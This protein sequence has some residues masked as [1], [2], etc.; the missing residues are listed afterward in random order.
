MPGR[1]RKSTAT[2]A[3]GDPADPP[4][5]GEQAETHVRPFPSESSVR[6]GAAQEPRT[7]TAKATR[8]TKPGTRVQSPQ[9]A[10]RPPPRSAGQPRAPRAGDIL[11]RPLLPSRSAP[12]AAGSATSQ[13]RWRRCPGSRLARAR[14]LRAPAN[15]QPRQ[16]RRL[17]ARP[18]EATRLLTNSPPSAAP[19]EATAASGAP[20]PGQPAYPASPSACSTPHAPQRLSPPGERVTWKQSGSRRP[21][22]DPSL[23]RRPPPIAQAATDRALEAGRP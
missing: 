7:V 18:P 22:S 15:R 19:A 6:A 23:C 14:S 1:P 5:A 13:R 11:P 20:R 9:L 16:G 17:P 3:P 2:P 12:A 8:E 10:A 21:S 4:S